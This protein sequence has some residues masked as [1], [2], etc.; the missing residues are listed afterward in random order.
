MLV[1]IEKNGDLVGCYH[2][3]TTN[4]QTND[5]QGKI[6]LLSQWNMEGWWVVVVVWAVL[7]NMGQYRA[8]LVYI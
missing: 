6:G 1:Y 8:V 3:G 7:G 4:Q 2:S 5:E